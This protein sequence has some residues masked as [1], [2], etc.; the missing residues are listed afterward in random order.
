M[1]L[2]GWAFLGMAPFGSLLAGWT[3][4]RLTPAS[5]DLLT[6]AS[7]TLLIAGSITL[8]CTLLYLTQLPAVR[9]AARP[10]YIQKGILPEMAAA[11]Q[12]ADEASGAE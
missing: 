8:T 12:V 10:I 11:L 6:G 2:F 5:G 1:S 9:R 7:R 4:H 3:A